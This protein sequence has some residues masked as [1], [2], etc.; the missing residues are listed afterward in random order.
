MESPPFKQ[1]SNKLVK[2]V[3]LET[4]IAFFFHR[5]GQQP[6]LN[7]VSELDSKRKVLGVAT[8]LLLLACFTPVPFSMITPR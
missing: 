3:Q 4:I 2:K 1:R 8:Y 5:G 6:P 7:D